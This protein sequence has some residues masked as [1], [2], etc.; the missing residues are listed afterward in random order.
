MFKENEN[1]QNSNKKP[2]IEI[3]MEIFKLCNKIKKL[4]TENNSLKKELLD[5]NENTIV[6]SM[7]DMKI[8]FEELK[9]NSIS[10]DDFDNLKDYYIK[11][12]EISKTI[13]TINQIMMDNLMEFKHFTN[14]E[15]T[16]QM[17]ENK[18]TRYID[19]TMHYYQL[20]NE[21]TSRYDGDDYI[22]PRFT[23]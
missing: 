5:L 1:I 9:E 23:E 15:Y 19:K 10:I 8:Q 13:K 16:S 2:Q 17:V 22:D 20:I 4:E 12:F 14:N 7:N 6:E 11:N 18:R 21:I 3:D